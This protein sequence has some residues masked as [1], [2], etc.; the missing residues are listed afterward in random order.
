LVTI[1]KLMAPIAPFYAD[2]IFIDLNK[3]TGNEK[4]D[5]V[6]LALI[7]EVNENI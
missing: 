6:H 2:K 1:T 4:A 3:V 5:S 7:P